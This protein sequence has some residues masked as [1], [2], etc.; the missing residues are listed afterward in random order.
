MKQQMKESGLEFNM[1]AALNILFNAAY[2][3]DLNYASEAIEYHTDEYIDLIDNKR[4]P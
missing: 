3:V 2:D 1:F 4:T